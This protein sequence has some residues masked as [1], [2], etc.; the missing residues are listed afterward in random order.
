MDRRTL[1]AAGSAALATEALAGT[2]L[3]GFGCGRGVSG[4]VSLG[5]GDRRPPGR[6]QQHRERPVAAREPAADG[7]RREV[8]RC[9]QQLRTVAAGPGPGAELG[10]NT[11]RF[12]IEW[13]RIEPEP[14]ALLDG[15]ARS[16]PADDRGLPRARPYAGGDVQP[17]HLPPVVLGRRRLAE[18]GSTPRCS[19]ATASA[20]RVTW[21]RASATP[22]P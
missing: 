5:R 3:G 17:L 18:P 15:D 11:Y 7:V 13:A 19:R 10:L 4:R 9:L 2:S 20:R 12:S 8:R 6:G 14:R 16:L 1:L 22:R 21:A